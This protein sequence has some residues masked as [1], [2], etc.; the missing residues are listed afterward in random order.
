MWEI[1]GKPV[2]PKRFMPFE[3]RR[4]LNYYDGP[5]IFTFRDAADA[6]CLAC[7]SDEDEQQSRFLV[8][9]VTDQI[10]ADLE[11]GLISVREALAQPRLWIVDWTRDGTLSGAWLVSHRDVPE[12][13]QPQPGTMLH[14]TLLPPPPD[15]Y[16][17][18][19]AEWL[20]N[21]GSMRTPEEVVDDIFG[22]EE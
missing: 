2:D 10:V 22:K 15:D 20:A 13:C 21:I 5:R 6:L 16:L 3:P 4:V 14:R 19:E 8:V 17:H 11:G 18:D 12:E 7:W 1:E 9:A